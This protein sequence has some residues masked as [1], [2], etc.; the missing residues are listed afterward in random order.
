MKLLPSR[1]D[2]CTQVLTPDLRNRTPT[3]THFL[4]LQPKTLACL[5]QTRIAHS[6]VLLK[7]PAVR[8]R[9]VPR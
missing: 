5:T 7:G 2:P 1:S 9:R 4:P 3:H 8:D 6:L